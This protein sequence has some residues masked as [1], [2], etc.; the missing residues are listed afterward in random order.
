MIRDSYKNFFEK[1]K[2][3]QNKLI[4]YGVEVDTIYPD[5]EQI[6]EKWDELNESYLN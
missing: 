3:D 5:P 4:E 2:I 1:F 6:R